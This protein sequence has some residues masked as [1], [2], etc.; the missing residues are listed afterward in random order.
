MATDNGSYAVDTA[1]LAAHA[2]NLNNLAGELRSVLAAERTVTVAGDVF[3]VTCQPF[4]TALQALD[5]AGQDT[6]L[7]GVN[8][9]DTTT[10]KVRNTATAY[11]DQEN[12]TANRFAEIGGITGGAG[13]PASSE[14]ALTS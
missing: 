6:L 4:A 10:T 9:M 3:G 7:A 2:R 8:A 11:E 5:Q 12:T 14:G 1:A 13:Q